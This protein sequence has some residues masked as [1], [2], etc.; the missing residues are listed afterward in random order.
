M[1]YYPV[2]IRMDFRGM[3]PSE[4]VSIRTVSIRMDF[5]GMGPSERFFHPNGFH[6][7]LGPSGWRTPRPGVP[8]VIIF[9]GLD[10]SGWNMMGRKSENGWIVNPK[11]GW[12]VNPKL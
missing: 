8:T 1:G 11:T 6:P 3:G 4:R 2:F 12:D 7:E 9:G 10:S 5:R